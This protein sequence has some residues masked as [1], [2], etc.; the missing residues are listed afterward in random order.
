MCDL[1]GNKTN[2]GVKMHQPGTALQ[3]RKQR[4][5]TGETLEIKNEA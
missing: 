3:A 4:A 1:D 5:V 2:G